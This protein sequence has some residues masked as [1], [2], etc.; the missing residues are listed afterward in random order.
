MLPDAWR[1]LIA[2]G[3]EGS[4]SLRHGH[5]TLPAYREHLNYRVMSTKQ[6]KPVSLPTRGR[7]AVRPIDGDAGMREE[8]K[9]MPLC[10]GADIGCVRNT[11]NIIERK[12]GLTSL[13]CSTR[14]SKVNRLMRQSS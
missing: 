6:D 8:R 5:K 7:D 2:V 13:R 10:N 3:T 14:E 1:A 9:R 4:D 12:S 11:N